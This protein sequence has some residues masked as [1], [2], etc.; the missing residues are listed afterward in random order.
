MSDKELYDILGIQPNASIDEIKKAY[1]K[2]SKIHH[3]DK[4]GDTEMFKKINSAHE[5]LIDPQKREIYDRHGM[6]GLKNSGQVPEDVFSSMFGNIFQDAGPF[7]NMFNMFRNVHNV[8]RKT[9]P[10]IHT[11]SVSLEDLC[12]NKIVKLR[13]TRDR[14]CKSCAGSPCSSCGGKGFS[15]IIR[16]FGPMIQQSQQPCGNCEGTGNIY[17]SCDSCKNGV[18]Q[19]AKTFELNLNPE[20][21]N[22]YEFRFENEGNQAKK[23]EIGDFIVRVN[24]KEHPV[25]K[26]EGR[27]L[28]YKHTISLKEA[29]CGHTFEILHPSGELISVS[30][31]QVIDPDTIQIIPKGMTSNSVMKIYYKIEFPKNLSEEQIKVLKDNL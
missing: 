23:F 18:T 1:R 31:N 4:G 9:A 10:Y 16:Q 6:A 3:P 7:G 24:L 22:G 8:V 11:I 5:I 28:I 12:T 2:Q 13:V 21:H 14:V 30:T 20:L 27:N 26:T 25:F 19:D 15:V 29:L 17:S